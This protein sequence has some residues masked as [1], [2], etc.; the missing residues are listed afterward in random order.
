[1]P[2]PFADRLTALFAQGLSD[3]D[4][5]GALGMT[6]KHVQRVRTRLG[7]FRR[8]CPTKYRTGRQERPA[9][10]AAETA[11]QQV[12]RMRLGYGGGPELL[13]TEGLSDG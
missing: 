8:R 13:L 6:T 10:R 2:S 7:L 4:L 5:A 11:Y 9:P 12:V 1:M 3:R